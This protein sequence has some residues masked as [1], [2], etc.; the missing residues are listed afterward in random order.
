MNLLTKIAILFGRRKFEEFAQ[1]N[2][3]LPDDALAVANTLDTYP[4]RGAVTLVA[5]SLA[6]SLDNLLH[7]TET[8]DSAAT[9]A[10]LILA[11]LCI[12]WVRHAISKHDVRVNDVVQKA[13]DLSGITAK[14]LMLIFVP[15]VFFA[16][17]SPSASAQTNITA[18][19]FNQLVTAVGQTT[20]FSSGVGINFHGKIAPLLSQ[21][22]ALFGHTG[23]NSSWSTASVPR[24]VFPLRRE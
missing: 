5:A 9:H 24:H 17:R 19:T 1:A 3:A 10:L 6:H 11:A 15:F 2:P 13:R 23:T 22:L 7:G 8:V 14:S 12:I 4:V 21:E 18:D 20:K 16:V